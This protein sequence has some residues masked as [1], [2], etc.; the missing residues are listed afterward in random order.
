MEANPTEPMAQLIA[1]LGE[2]NKMPLGP[3]RDKKSQEVQELFIPAAEELS[4][5][6]DTMR[7]FAERNQNGETLKSFMKKA[8]IDPPVVVTRTTPQPK[9]FTR[10]M[11][12]RLETWK[13]FWDR[14]KGGLAIGMT[15]VAGLFFYANLRNIKYLHDFTHENDLVGL[16]E[17][18]LG[19]EDEEE[20][21]TPLDWRELENDDSV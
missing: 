13:N 16:F 4:I 20:R 14:K 3:E 8:G 18:W 7:V 17:D 5:L 10:I 21:E 12:S 19:I 9:P 11:K 15:L 1:K 2:L 6:G